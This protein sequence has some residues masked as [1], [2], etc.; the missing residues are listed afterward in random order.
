[1]EQRFTTEDSHPRDRF[2]YWREAVC[3]SYVRL[4]CDTANPLRFRGSIDL[5]RRK[6]LSTSHVRGS[7][8]TVSRRQRDVSK[9]DDDTFLLS[10]QL[11]QTGF[12]EQ[13][14]RLVRLNPG[15][16]ALYN[17][18]SR[19]RLTL[20]D[21]FAQL[22]LQFPKRDFLERLPSAE[23]LTALKVPSQGF[24][25][26]AG[27]VLPRLVSALDET[28]EH[29]Q[30]E[31]QNAILDLLVAALAGMDAGRHQ[32]HSHNQ[33]ILL[34]ARE[35]IAKELSNTNLNREAVA[36]AVGL[37]VRRLNEVF[38]EDSSSISR[39][40]MHARLSRIA[41]Q[42]TNPRHAHKSISEIAYSN[43]VSSLQSFSRNF[44]KRFEITPA[45]FRINA[46][47]QR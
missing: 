5:K 33:L 29:A 37:S 9:S 41:A 31:S 39:E 6:R 22:V 32:F 18:S 23:N 3:D 44:R 21:G 12:V 4:E 10:F 28:P 7:N 26:V 17:S 45:D 27:E 24:G 15:E 34:R 42:L 16:F 14:G 46:T 20:P 25:A 19:Y 8:Q 35:F 36:H 38:Q 47:N 43:G 13:D 1:M 40:I 11:C 2:A 30:E